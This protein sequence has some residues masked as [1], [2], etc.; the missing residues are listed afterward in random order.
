MDT[1]GRE[2]DMLRVW[3]IPDNDLVSV[4]LRITMAR[5]ASFDATDEFLDLYMLSF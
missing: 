2:R 5:L 3:G 4:W 1:I